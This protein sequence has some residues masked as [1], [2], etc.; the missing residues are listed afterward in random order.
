MVYNQINEYS[1]EDQHNQEETQEA[2]NL[3]V[4]VDDDNLIYNFTD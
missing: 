3:H 1:A 4:A 2:E